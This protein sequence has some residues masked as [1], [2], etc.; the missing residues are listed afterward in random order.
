MKKSTQIYQAY[1]LRLWYDEDGSG[2]RAILEDVQTNHKQG[3]AGI[4]PLLAHI[5][6]QVSSMET[7]PNEIL[8]KQ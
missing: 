6:K 4:D 8:N 3:Y 1:L 7:H 2:F 5:K